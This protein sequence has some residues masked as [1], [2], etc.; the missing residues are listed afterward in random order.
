MAGLQHLKS[1][2]GLN[3]D[4]GF[5]P[6]TD[7][8][9]SVQTE[10]DPAGNHLPLADT[11]AYDLTPP[12]G[13]PTPFTYPSLADMETGLTDPGSDIRFS[14]GIGFP[15]PAMKVNVST[16]GA[17]ASVFYIK[18]M[19]GDTLGLSGA[20]NKFGKLSKVLSK[21]GIDTPNIDFNAE[22]NDIFAPNSITYQQTVKELTDG[23]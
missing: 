20:V 22:I 13:P 8:H 23:I 19:T 7:L 9:N 5:Q 10:L 2:Y 18:T 15:A 1:A 21:A 4:S 11:S 16:E 17:Q 6:E 12:I 3:Q 14:A